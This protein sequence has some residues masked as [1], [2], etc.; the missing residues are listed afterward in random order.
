[1]TELPDDISTWSV[2]QVYEYFNSHPDR[3]D[4]AQFFKDQKIKGKHLLKLTKEDLL[5]KVEL[6]T[7]MEMMDFIEELQQKQV[8][9][10]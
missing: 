7:A 1:M 6:G 9:K 4:Y 2:E 5:T 8:S 3:K 10:A